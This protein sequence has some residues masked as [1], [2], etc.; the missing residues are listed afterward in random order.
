M[1]SW[2]KGT[3]VKSDVKSGE[4]VK[5]VD[6]CFRPT[7]ITH[8]QH[9]LSTYLSPDLLSKILIQKGFHESLSWNLFCKEIY[10]ESHTMILA[11]S[12]LCQP[13]Y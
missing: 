6:D 9:P 4:C 8:R 13:L 11:L 12:N 5:H 3:I 7:S 1:H 2:V 10:A